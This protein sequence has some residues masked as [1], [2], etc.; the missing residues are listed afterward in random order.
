ML[1]GDDPGA[2]AV[3]TVFLYG[4]A[5]SEPNASEVLG[6]AAHCE[7]ATLLGG[8]LRRF[9]SGRPLLWS[10]DLA[11]F[12]QQQADRVAGSESCTPG[13]NPGYVGFG[14]N[15]FYGVVGQSFARYR[16]CLLAAMFSAETVEA[17]PR[18]SGATAGA[19][20][21]PRSATQAW[22]EQG[23]VYD[24]DANACTAGQDCAAFLQ[25]VWRNTTAFGCAEALCPYTGGDINGT[26][27]YFVCN[28]WPAA[29]VVDG[30]RPY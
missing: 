1:S 7:R 6:A 10:K 28:Y 12:A 11:A 23:K 20:Y 3:R 27:Q 18:L 2:A 25:V 24:E 9:F 5:C 22:I 26:A 13:Y 4:P 19:R 8:R 15:V 17:D 16:T 30:T 14:E 29:A 21:N